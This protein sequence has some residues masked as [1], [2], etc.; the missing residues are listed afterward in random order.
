MRRARIGQ[1][2]QAAVLAACLGGRPSLA[3]DPS[4]ALDQ[5]GHDAWRIEQGLPQDTVEAIG[6]TADGYLWVGTQRGLA[7]FDGAGFTVF[8]PG[9]VAALRSPAIDSLLADPDGSLWITTDGGGLLRYRDGSF[10]AVD[11]PGLPPRLRSLLRDPDGTLWIGSNQGGLLHLKGGSMLPD[12][13]S[14]LAGST[15]TALRRDRD[16]SL[17]IGTDHGLAR[18]TAGRLERFTTRDGLPDDRINEILVDSRGRLW[19]G[20][21]R[22]LARRSGGRIDVSAAP[23]LDGDD[24]LALLEDR[25]GSLWIGTRRGLGRLRDGRFESAPLADEL[26]GD[27]IPTL[28]E[29]REGSL[30]VGT[31]S[32]GLHRLKDVAFTG[33]GRAAGLSGSPVWAVLEDSRGRVWIGS[34]GGLDLLDGGRAAPFPGPPDLRGEVVRAIAEDREGSF[35]IGTYRGLYR[36]QSGLRGGRVSLYTTAEGLSDNRVLTLL[37]DREGALWAGTY[38][39]LNRLQDGRV[40]VYTHDDGLLNDRIFALHQDR[41]GALWIGTKEGLNRLAGGRIEAFP[42][43]TGGPA[44]SVFSLQEDAEGTLWIGAADGLFRYRGGTFT[45]F[46]P[47]EGLPEG[48]VLLVLDDGLGNLWVCN[49]GLLRIRKDD[50]ATF[51]TQRATQRAAQRKG[52]IRSRAFGAADG[53]PSSECSGVGRP[54]GLRSRDGRVWFP[55]VRG[56]AVAHPAHLPLN[57][58]PPPVVVE[59][60]TAGSRSFPARGEVRLPPGTDRFQIRY[61]ALSFADPANVLFRHKLEGFDPDWVEAGARRSADYTNLPPGAY[62][63]RVAACNDD[64]LWSEVVS[65]PLRVEPRIFQKAW[66]LALSLMALFLAILGT[67]R[68]RE[69]TLRRRGRALAALVEERTHALMDEKRRAEGA[70]QEAEDA[71]RA[72]TEFLANVSHEIRTPMNAVIGMTSVLLRTPLS[73]EQR[74]YVDTI[75]RSGEDLLVILNDILD[76]S[77]IEAGR[78]EI[79][80]IPFRVVD[81]VKEAMDLLAEGAARKGLKIGSRVEPN[82][83]TVVVSDATR[84]RQVLVNLIGNAVKFTSEGEVFV[85]VSARAAPPGPP[86]GTLP[87]PLPGPVVELRFVIRDT[88]P[89]I[90]MDRLDRLFKPFSQADSST[91]RLFGGTG[92]GLA[93]SQRLVERLGGTIEVES[94]PG[95][96]AVFSFTIRCEPAAVVDEPVLRDETGEIPPGLFRPLR[97]LL[98]EDNSINQ[99]VALLLLERLGYAADVA[100]NGLETLAALRRQ[101]YDVVLMD[102]QMP[103]M[104]GLEAARRIVAEPPRG[105]RPRIIAMTA[106]A[107]R[108]DRDACLAAGMDDYLSKPILLED[109]RAAL[110]RTHAIPAGVAMAGAPAAEPHPVLDPV[111]LDRLL[112]LQRTSGRLIVPTIVDSFVTEGPRRLE[113]MRGALARGDRQDLVLVAHTLKGGS[114][115]LGALRVAAVSKELEESGKDGQLDG[116]GEILDRLERELAAASAALLARTRMQETGAPSS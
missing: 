51:A 74:D 72:K 79:E 23:G 58:V 57:R 20:T 42:P 97:I 94:E 13:A 65:L 44:G 105:R 115:Q 101:D 2:L 52:R 1:I 40:T 85:S 66:F 6:Q 93:I 112:E 62:T 24:I 48:G 38:Q 70:Q 33:Y 11:P 73:R 64:G 60:I 67:I 41:S 76:L 89:G 45:A 43:R 81:C 114:A 68:L 31:G 49:K 102:V 109:L 10:T 3:L 59:E 107:L 34:D 98:A 37:E 55:T 63:F 54:A 16:G 30:W 77:K 87:G 106:N 15:V 28:F 22:G 19:I 84:L 21:A 18:L 78:L 12:A 29:D 110:V 91:T 100:A 50:L 80:A 25:D 90:P 39:G 71:S 47:A 56:V 96:G 116:T 5:Y 14:G 61:T 92:L 99:K 82:V 36:L 32:G 111:Y 95:K 113:R 86:P 27:S 104:D 7:R 17:W 9:N 88:G 4:H 8:A 103:E 83:P 108:R 53:M 69:R 46:T 75:R 26:A 35:W